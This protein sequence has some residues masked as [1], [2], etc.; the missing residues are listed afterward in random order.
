[1]TMKR[2]VRDTI[3]EEYLKI[4]IKAFERG[5]DRP[6]TADLYRKVKR[7]PK[8]LVVGYRHHLQWLGLL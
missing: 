1:M 5:D 7:A 8:E 4:M 2:Y 3:R 6:E